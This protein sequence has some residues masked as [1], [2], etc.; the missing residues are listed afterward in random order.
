[1][2][3][4]A[5]RRLASLLSQRG[6]HVLRFDYSCTGDSAGDSADAQL[7]D[8]RRDIATAVAE[9]K[10]IAGVS[11]VSIIGL[12]LGASLAAIA[13]TEGL[14]IRDLIL[15]EP[16]IK[17]ESYVTGLVAVGVRKFARLLFHD[18]AGPDELLGFPFPKAIAADTCAV[19][20]TKITPKARRA[21]LVTSVATDEQSQLV[22]LFAAAK[23]NAKRVE[24]KDESGAT[25]ES[26]LLS[27][28]AM[29][30]IVRTLEEP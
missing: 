11:Q 4:W 14:A 10:D 26:A 27:T 7:V 25:K 13:T 18:R 21:L 2:T 15:W 20:L 8:W 9:L 22:E 12:R 23:V 29:Q 1:M 30:T 6:F 5:M 16:V 3:H 24:V 19:D 17:G 28:A